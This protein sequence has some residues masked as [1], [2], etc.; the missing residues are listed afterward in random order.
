M[1]ISINSPS[2]RRATEV[3]ILDYLP[4]CRIWVDKSEATEYRKHNPNAEIIEC[5]DG[6]QGNTSR[7]RNYILRQE[8]KRGVDVVV[9]MDD[10]VRYLERFCEGANKFGYERVKI[11]SEDILP[12][13]EKYSIMAADIGAKMWGVNCNSDGR[14]YMQQRPFNTTSFIGGPFQVFLKGNRCW[15]DEAIPLKEDYD[16]VLQQLN[17]E[18]IVL[19]VN[20]IHYIC[21]QSKNKGGC[22]VYRNRIREAEQ[23]NLLQAKWGSQIVQR[24]NGAK[25]RNTKKSRLFE[26][27]NPII[28]PPIRG[29]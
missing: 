17:L 12:L 3:K 11:P 15:Y 4:F 7:I 22:A 19:R 27:Y 29:V 23:F 20:A 13:I 5:L 14:G 21:E 6:V 1:K 8:F 25:E 16:M 24:D 10:D 2:Y 26:D 9:L 18:R 28:K